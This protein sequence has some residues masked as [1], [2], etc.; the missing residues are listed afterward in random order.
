MPINRCD[1]TTGEM[2]G[3]K[4]VDTKKSLHYESFRGKQEEAIDSI[5]QSQNTVLVMPTGGGK[6]I[7]YTV[8][9]LMEQKIVVVIFPLLALLLDQV[10]RMKSRGLNVCFL[11]NDMDDMERLSYTK[12]HFNPPEYNCLFLTPETVLSSSAYLT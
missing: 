1:S 2:T 12:L 11:M 9:A 3:K 10:E 7:C 6:S 5:C 8:P 4:S